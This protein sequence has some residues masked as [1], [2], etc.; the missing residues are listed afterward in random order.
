MCILDHHVGITSWY[1]Q[2]MCIQDKHVDIAIS[3]LLSKK[4]KKKILPN[5]KK[6]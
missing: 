1:P 3:D 6:T 4:K 5:K 2:T